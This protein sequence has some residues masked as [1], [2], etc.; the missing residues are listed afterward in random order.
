MIEACWKALGRTPSGLLP[1][2]IRHAIHWGFM[3]AV[4]DVGGNN[5]SSLRM[6]LND[7]VMITN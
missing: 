7:Q 4:I 2:A 6:H 3:I 1:N 5:L